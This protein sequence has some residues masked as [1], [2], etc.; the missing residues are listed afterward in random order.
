[1]YAYIFASNHCI[2]H[3][4]FWMS[5]TMSLI[6]QNQFPNFALEGREPNFINS[7]LKKGCIPKLFQVYG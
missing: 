3:P 5:Y 2:Y 7:D 6:N 4:K 1:M